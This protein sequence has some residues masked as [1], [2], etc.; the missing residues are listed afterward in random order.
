ML[1]HK[2]NNKI[3]NQNSPPLCVDLDGTLVKLDTL[4]QSILLLI[5]RKPK[6]IFK[7]IKWIQAGRAALKEEVTKR[8]IKIIS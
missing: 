8:L 7:I 4:H 3:E 6:S 2:M 1:L 5:R